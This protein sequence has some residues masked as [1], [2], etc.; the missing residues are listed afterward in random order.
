MPFRAFGSVVAA[1]AVTMLSSCAAAPAVRVNDMSVDAPAIDATVSAAADNTGYVSWHE[2]K[3]GMRL[4][5]PSGDPTPEYV[6]G[7]V[8]NEIN[9]LVTR[10]EAQ[11]RDIEI[12]SKDRTDGHNDASG[13]VGGRG[14]LAAFPEHV[15]DELVERA[16]LVM[17][18]RR[19]LIAGETPRGYYDAHR[20]EFLKPCT[21][22]IVVRTRAK[23]EEARDDIRDGRAFADVAREV[24]IDEGTAPKGGG[25]GC[26]GVGD[27]VPELDRAS[28]T[29]PVGEVGEPIRTAD[30]YHL[31]LVESRK[32]PAFDAVKGEAAGAVDRLGVRRLSD[33][34]AERLRGA[35]VEVAAGYGR[36]DDQRLIVVPG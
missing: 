27:L 31:L 30:G 22:H 13:T 20:D 15:A 4:L 1:A 28:L 36:W 3:S 19:T 32:T 34:L 16:S 6:A 14:V 11:R 8:T 23:A 5:D 12:T 18:F 10:A 7:V 35:T 9:H 33:I 2:Q 25:L 26:N 24:S 21:R 29:Q 17:A